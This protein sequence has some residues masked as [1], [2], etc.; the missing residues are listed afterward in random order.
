M[1]KQML[2]LACKPSQ[3]RPLDGEDRNAGCVQTDQQSATREARAIERTSA[4]L[5][6]E[7]YGLSES[8]SLRE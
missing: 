1:L 3:V 2:A 7:R 5:A 8:L 6:C 4:S